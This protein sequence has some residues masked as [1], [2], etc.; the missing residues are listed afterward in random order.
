[1]R[2]MFTYVLIAVAAYGG[3][4]A[5][6]FIF[7]RNLLYH[8]SPGN[9]DPAVYGVPE[10]ERVHIQAQ[11]GLQLVAWY[12]SA[13]EG[14]Q[15]ILFLHGNAGHIGHRSGKVKLYLDKGYGVLLLSYRGFGSNAGSPTEVNL[16]I[17]GRAALKFLT[18]RHVPL[19]KLAIYGESLGTGVAVELARHVSINCLILEAPF[20]SVPDLAAHHYFFL[21]VSLL[22]KDRFASLK[23]ITEIKSPTYFIHGEF[24][25]VIPWSFGKRL[26]EAAPNPKELLLIT[27]A[28]HNNLYDYGVG[29]K[30]I[31]FLEKYH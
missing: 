12:R 23:K 22:V 4:I 20:T 2:R 18:E 25:R 6:S 11:D 28:G 24:D 17:D 21:P 10:M 7:Q 30:V 15:T 13:E 14:K 1:M 16:Y 31:E 26:Y 8:P 5:I 27:N 3:L 19:K 9:M 29:E